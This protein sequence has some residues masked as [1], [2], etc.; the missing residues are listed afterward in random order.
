MTDTTTLHALVQDR[1]TDVA[2]AAAQPGFFTFISQAIFGG[3]LGCFLL[4]AG[5][6][7]LDDTPNANLDP[8]FPLTLMGMVGIVIG[9]PVGLFMWVFTKLSGQVPS[10]SFRVTIAL[11]LMAIIGFAW[12]LLIYDTNPTSD[13][14]GL[15]FLW[16]SVP[17]IV[18]GLLTGSSLRPGR[19]LVRG[20]D[21]ILLLPRA[22]LSASRAC[23]ASAAG[24][25]P[26][27]GP[28]CQSWDD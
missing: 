26:G 21:A 27:L 8:F 4:F 5:V 6:M 25:A 18:M 22:W 28:A 16:V 20:G 24:R 1:R 19:E 3:T 13:A 10:R 7:L 9:T 17:G 12:L 14:H 15:V 2:Q 23:V 11:L